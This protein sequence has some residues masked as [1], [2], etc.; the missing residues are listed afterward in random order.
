MNK[1][2]SMSLLALCFSAPSFADTMVMT[3]TK[4][5]KKQIEEKVKKEVVKKESKE[6][7]KD[8]ALEKKV[9]IKVEEKIDNK[10]EEKKHM[11]RDAITGKKVEQK[12]IV[13]PN[14]PKETLRDS[15]RKK[16]E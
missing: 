15:V 11:V 16:F 8:A 7:I 2:I 3:P 1:F 9:D 5:T 4:E 12:Q 13:T 10:V 14:T 6:K